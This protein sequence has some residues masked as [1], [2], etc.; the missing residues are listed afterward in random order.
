MSAIYSSWSLFQEHVYSAVVSGGLMASILLAVAAA[1]A[2][3]LKRR[4]T[5]AAARC[6]VWTATVVCLAG[7]P[8]VSQLMPAWDLPVS[9]PSPGTENEIVEAPDNHNEVPHRATAS[10][11]TDVFA[12]A[13]E[14]ASI[15]T[16]VLPDSQVPATKT[17]EASPIDK[18]LATVP[19]IWPTGFVAV[20]GSTVLGWCSLLYLRLTSKDTTDPV[21]LKELHDLKNQ[22]GIRRD[23]RLVV[24]QR[25]AI[26][27]A[28]GL[29][30]P[31]IHLPSAA[32]N[33]NE[34]ARRAVL[35]HELA[36]IRR[37]DYPVQL[38]ARLVCAIYW[39]NPL[40]WI[41]IWKLRAEQEASC[42]DAVLNQGTSAASYAK[43]LTQILVDGVRSRWETAV[44]LAAVRAGRLEQRVTDIL[45]TT[46]NRR[47]PSIRQ[48]VLCSVLIL[49]A[50][51]AIA[52]AGP[53]KFLSAH[54]K[55]AETTVDGANGQKAT[56]KSL[57]DIRDTVLKNY[58]RQLDRE[59]ITR[60]A[61]DGMLESLNDPYSQYISPKDLAN[62]RISVRGELSGIGARLDKKDD[63]PVISLPLPGSPALAAG[64]KPGDVILE[65]DSVSAKSLELKEVA[66][67]IRGPVGSVV[68]LKIRRGDD[69]TEVKV[70]RDKIKLSTVRGFTALQAP[71]DKA[72]QFRIDATSGIGYVHLS[73][74][75]ENTPG[76]LR[77]VLKKLD[78]RGLKGVILDLRFCP[79]GTLK[80]AIGVVS[81]FVR[82]GK[83]VVIRGRDG[84][85][86]ARNV[87]ADSHLGDYPLV[88]IVNELTASAGEIV[89]GALQD[90]GRAKIVGTRTFGKASVQTLL[91]LSD[92]LGAIK[93]TTA[94]YCP[95]NGRNIDRIPG[96]ATWGIDADDGYFVD[97][98]ADRREQLQKQ[99]GTIPAQS[100]KQVDAI[101]PNTL[102]S[103]AGDPQLAAALQ[104]LQAK[105]RT[106][107][108]PK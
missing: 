51:V 72:D 102:R 9:Q 7:L 33:W 37:H 13:T 29:L 80:A 103:E 81:L 24:S 100:R 66:S 68:A 65:I 93:L 75:S 64:L 8:L 4:R 97:V 86:N 50:A 59:S 22:M 26:P 95:P 16:P 76:E 17:S 92:E 101:T 27:M 34:D 63:F 11:A 90:H 40:A 20:F 96:K 44:A 21:I 94:F 18:L 19:V 6:Q 43:H 28:W 91:P 104:T 53:L 54:D 108:L 77:D 107:T 67:R 49:G 85:E 98:P 48:S 39:Y 52:T 73:S 56:A 38:V 74:L 2:A 25:R 82:E 32:A 15:G 105:L 106:E 31:T 45:S 87:T 3:I 47:S 89:A 5:S 71:K 57:A 55:T 88:V 42:D 84:K 78:K 69:S 1:I 12:A 46:R 79:G 10:A 23:I 60:S 62:L 83:V 30:R 61:I 36:H 99:F 70:T 35:L 41:A 58:V 14:T